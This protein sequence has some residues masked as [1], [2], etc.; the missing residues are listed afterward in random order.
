MTIFWR[1]QV[2]YI[3]DLRTG[4]FVGGDI[5]VAAAIQFPL[6]V[7]G[8]GSSFFVVVKLKQRFHA[9]LASGK[10][11]PRPS[12]RCTSQFLLCYAS[13]RR[14]FTKIR[15]DVY[16]TLRFS[17][18][19]TRSVRTCLLSEIF[20]LCSSLSHPCLAPAKKGGL[21]CSYHSKRL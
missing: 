10:T 6:G 15:A 5:G 2:A 14:V 19:N 17:A 7:C 3:I 9:R 11:L 21:V 12:L 18:P 1:A 4:A 16:A 8:T 13:K 20:A